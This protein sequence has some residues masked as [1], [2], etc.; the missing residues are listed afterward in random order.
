M[1][2]EAKEWWTIG[3]MGCF[4]LV[5]IYMFLWF[6]VDVGTC[7]SKGGRMIRTAGIRGP[8][9]LVEGD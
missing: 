2:D 9:C 1:S 4:G 7:E 6:M 8:V 5:A 3:A